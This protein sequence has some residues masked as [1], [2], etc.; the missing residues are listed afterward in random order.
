[1]TEERNALN[2]N[3]LLTD[4]NTL[5][6]QTKEIKN[7]RVFGLI[8]KDRQLQQHAEINEKLNEI[9]QVNE[10][11]CETKVPVDEHGRRLINYDK[12]KRWF[13][14]NITFVFAKGVIFDSKDADNMSYLMKSFKDE[15]NQAYLNNTYYIKDYSDEVIKAMEHEVKVSNGNY[16]IIMG[17][18]C[19]ANEQALKEAPAKS[20]AFK[21]LIRVATTWPEIF[22]IMTEYI[23]NYG[24]I[25]EY[26]G[27]TEIHGFK[28]GKKVG[29]DNY[30]NANPSINV[31]DVIN[32][33]ISDLPGYD[34]VLKQKEYFEHNRRE[35]MRV[36]QSFSEN[37]RGFRK[38]HETDNRLRNG[39]D[40]YSR[41]SNEPM[42]DLPSKQ[43]GGIYKADEYYLPKEQQ[44]AEFILYNDLNGYDV[45]SGVNVPEN[46]NPAEKSIIP[47]FANKN[48]NN[49]RKVIPNTT[50]IFPK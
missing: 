40:L 32:S 41:I 21:G 24:F 23:T 33:Q 27:K 47:Q 26:Y 10:F 50:N 14:E 44:Q 48:V 37:Q 12:G 19:A 9:K 3:I 38:H 7:P 42:M 2:A 11:L 46:V 15:P 17:V 35:N 45:S 39:N 16:H 13:Y 5:N 34:E 28:D 29:R 8:S 49:S 6:A 20:L 4:I 25:F 43:V 31:M 22:K 36:G 30:M 1:M 18:F